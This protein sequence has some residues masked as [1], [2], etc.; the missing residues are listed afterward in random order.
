MLVATYE[1]PAAMGSASLQVLRLSWDVE[2]PVFCR[3]M[4]DKVFTAIFTMNCHK[5]W[6]HDTM[7]KRK[8][9]LGIVGKYYP[10]VTS[11]TGMGLS[12]LVQW[13]MPP[14]CPCHSRTWAVPAGT[15]PWPFHEAQQLPPS[16]PFSP[17][18]P[19][20]SGDERYYCYLA[21]QSGGSSANGTAPARCQ[22]RSRSPRNAPGQG[23]RSQP[24]LLLLLPCSAL[25][26]SQPSKQC[27][28]PGIK[29]LW[30]RCPSPLSG[31]P[32]TDWHMS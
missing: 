13:A 22:L 26:P 19:L 18:P 1:H 15:N 7:K 3:R 32:C 31:C 14:R 2:F 4:A 9:L 5:M 17:E 28:M 29:Q 24:W 10:G 30:G 21:Q 6:C 16:C 25:W 20:A 8:D 12:V 11:V 23:L 27:S